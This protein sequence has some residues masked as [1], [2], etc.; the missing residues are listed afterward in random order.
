MQCLRCGATFSEVQASIVLTPD[1]E[2]S[3]RF[4]SGTFDLCPMCATDLQLWFVSD[5]SEWLRS[6]AERSG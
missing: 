1:L 3:P 5:P 4:C 2:V 6:L